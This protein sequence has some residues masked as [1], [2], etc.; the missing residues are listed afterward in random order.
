MTLLG[1]ARE[2]QRAIQDLRRAAALELD[3]RIELWVAPLPA[4]LEPYIASV[5]GETLAEDVRAEEPPDGVSRT[6]VALDAGSVVIGLRRRA[7]GEAG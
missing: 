1:R 2:L 3:D 6:E 7:A 4:T 5:A